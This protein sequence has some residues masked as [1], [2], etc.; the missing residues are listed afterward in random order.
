MP[1]LSNIRPLLRSRITSSCTARRLATS[2]PKAARKP[3]STAP[4]PPPKSEFTPRSRPEL[5]ASRI[6]ESLPPELLKKQWYATKLY[7]SGQRA[8][9]RPPSHAGI[10]AASYIIAG[11][12]FI[13][14]GALA[15]SN[16]WAYEATSDLHWVVRVGWR[17]GIVTFTFIGGLAFLRPIRMVR[18]IDLVSVDGITKLAVQVRRPLPF[19]RP[20]EYIVAPY[21]FQMERTFVQQ[22]D[23]PE[24]MDKDAA[25]P[26]GVVSRLGRAVSQA[27]YY[28]F[29][30]TRRLMTLE[31]F[32]YVSL[33][34]GEG[35][36]KLD[37]QGKFSNGAKDLV[38]MGSIVL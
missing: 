20:K 4:L 21:E 34:Q 15:F 27:I 19:L 7:N 11:S 22:M 23:D 17:L 37:T 35:K 6:S 32:M 18:A 25:N 10:L 2:S 12:C 24:F 13:T 36:L 1:S 33:N 9:Y 30:A 26:L 29:A 5:P 31:G 38:K 8:I 3:N 28:P 16:L 14:A